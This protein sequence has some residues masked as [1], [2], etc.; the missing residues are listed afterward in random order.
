[1]TFTYTPGDTA[2]ATRVRL[3][4]GDTDPTAPLQQRLEN[5]EIT[6]LLT[7]SGGY[8]AGAAAAAD[9]L[10]AKFARL[11]TGKRM[12]QASLEWQRFKQ[13]TDLAKNLRSAVSLAA[14]P[15]AGGI[16]KTVR[17]NLAQDTDRITPSFQRGMLDNPSSVSTTSTAAA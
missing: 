6:D 5:E 15:F 7:I 14:V 11:A 16:S 13:L 8:R 3:L 17:D 10:A 2:D 12:G 4:I 1:M 9:A